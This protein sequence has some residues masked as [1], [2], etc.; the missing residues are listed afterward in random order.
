LTFRDA[1]LKLLAYVRDQI[2]NGELTERGFARLIGISQPH[3]HNVLLKGVRNLS[4]EFL[5]LALKYFHLSLLDL[6]TTEELEAHLHNRNLPQR[7]TEIPFLDGPLGPGMPW[8]TGRNRRKH[9]P[10]PFSWLDRPE[11]FVMGAL[12]PDPE[13][14]STLGFCDLALLDTSS[15]W[16][17]TLDPQGLFA[18]E[19]LN[20]GIAEAVLRYIRPGARFYYLAT[21]R[22][23]DTPG[24]WEPL[25]ATGIG[26]ASAVKARVRWLGRERDPSSQRGRFLYDPISS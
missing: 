14:P 23:L 12:L 21:D 8:P 13:M 5:D 19:R 24:A 11:N 4:P 7:F 2:R 25:P 3:V 20:Q 1:Q 6:V 9:F 26:V 18:V 16:L 15:A 22:T 17:S 10:L